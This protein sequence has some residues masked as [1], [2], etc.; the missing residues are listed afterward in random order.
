MSDRHN[1]RDIDEPFAVH[2]PGEET[3]DNKREKGQGDKADGEYR[4]LSK[5]EPTTNPRADSARGKQNPSAKNMRGEKNPFITVFQFQQFGRAEI[6][7]H[8]D[9]VLAVKRII[10]TH[11]AAHAVSGV[12]RGRTKTNAQS[13]CE[14]ENHEADQNEQ[15]E[16]AIELGIVVV[17]AQLTQ[18]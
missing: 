12:V 14:G 10:E 13:D 3:R 4:R 16:A 5:K 17:H 2:S 15:S 11:R 18:S 7:E 8:Y 6:P 9:V 1:K